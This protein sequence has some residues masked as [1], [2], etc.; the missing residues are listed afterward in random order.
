MKHFAGLLS[1][2]TISANAISQVPDTVFLGAAYINNV[3]Y[4]L[5]NGIEEDDVNND[6]DIAFQT[7]DAFSTSILINPANGTELYLYPGD[8]TD[9]LTLDT[10]GMKSGWTRLYNSDTSWNY[11][12]FSQNQ[13]T[14]HV[15][16][17]LYNMTTHQIHGDKLFVIR[18]SIGTYNKVWIKS[19]IGSVYT[20]RHSTLNNSMNMVHSLDKSAYS[21]K[22]FGFYSLQTHGQKDK[23]PLAA[24]WDLLFGKYTAMTPTVY[25]V[26]GVLHNAST[27]SSKA[28]PIS[29]VVNYI[30]W[31]QHTLMNE[32]NTIGYDWKVFNMTTFLY[33]IS[34][35][36]VYF[37]KTQHG[38]VWKI[39]F[40]HFGGSSNGAIGFLK[41]HVH[42]A[43][44]DDVKAISY[45]E[46]YPNPAGDVVTIASHSTS[47]LGI[48]ISD[49]AGREVISDIYPAS[50]LTRSLDISSLPSG[51]YLIS[52]R[53][54][55]QY[56][57]KKI[58]VE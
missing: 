27:Q 16:W 7:K 41:T 58:L 31:Q 23:E 9:Y 11:G 45:F 17:G 20:F 18:L 36:T 35:S 47:D 52:L 14:F 25:N 40:D 57:T 15:G 56:L 6:W 42:F 55:G 43:G 2:L 22:N 51:L 1:I 48:S 33:D 5:N 50:S 44:I 46:V 19:L 10:T 8:S 34:D 12:A 13:T 38:D 21:G 30:D 26:T 37:V 39:V 32:I 53:S 54:A 24:D 4:S 3:Y 28:Y 49:M 29:D